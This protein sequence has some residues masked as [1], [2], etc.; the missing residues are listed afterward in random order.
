MGELPRKVVPRE[1]R[2]LFDG[3]GRLPVGTFDRDFS[4]LD[5][6]RRLR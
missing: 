5:D 3:V 6:V 2:I 4:K 1:C